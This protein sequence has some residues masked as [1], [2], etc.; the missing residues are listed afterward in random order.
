V[1]T[2]THPGAKLTRCT[3]SSTVNR[4]CSEGTL[5]NGRLRAAGGSVE[6]GYRQGARARVDR[7]FGPAPLLCRERMSRL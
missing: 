4:S 2:L 3:Q 1:A 5:K 6:G 7:V